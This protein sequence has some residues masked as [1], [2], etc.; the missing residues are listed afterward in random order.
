MD[1]TTQLERLERRWNET[2]SVEEECAYLH[3]RVRVGS[4]TH[5]WLDLAAYCG[6]TAAR[7]AGG[8]T[9]D[10]SDDPL[11]DFLHET[12]RRRVREQFLSRFRWW[13]LGLRRWGPLVWGRAVSTALRVSVDARPELAPERPWFDHVFQA[14]ADWGRCPCPEHLAGVREFVAGDAYKHQH[15]RLGQAA[16]EAVEARLDPIM[17]GPF[18]GPDRERGEQAGRFGAWMGALVR[19]VERGPDVRVVWLHD[20]GPQEF[21]VRTRLAS[22]SRALATR[23]V[24]VSPTQCFLDAAKATS[25]AIVDQ[26]VRRELIAL[27]LSVDR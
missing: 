19:L 17:F 25:A 24:V 21:A 7:L 23:M 22:I 18:E 20:P 10:D 4:L 3:E 26:A 15:V 14:L 1:L 6:H 13:C 8:A 9:P 5:E 27:A 12:S 16:L 2:G 11:L